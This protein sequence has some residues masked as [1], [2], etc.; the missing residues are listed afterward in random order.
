M[1]RMAGT[2]GLLLRL[3]DGRNDRNVEGIDGQLKSSQ[4]ELLEDA[5]LFMHHL[6]C[7]IV[8]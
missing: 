4:E 6:L 8:V 1:T 5:K 3:D 2:T 7:A